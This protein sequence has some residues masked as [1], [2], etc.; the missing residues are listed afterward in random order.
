MTKEQKL[1]Y[2][3]AMHSIQSGVAMEMNYNEKIIDPKHLRVGVIS[4]MVE[5]SAVAALLIQKKL[6]SEE[7]YYDAIV[8]AVE[9][10]KEKFERELSERLGTKVT[11]A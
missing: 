10:E 2:H 6:I 7:E 8:T 1:R 3:S 4:A 9:T 11:L 5:I